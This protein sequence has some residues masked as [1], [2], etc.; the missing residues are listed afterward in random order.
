M[1][2]LC[3]GANIV[4]SIESCVGTRGEVDRRLL[5]I[6]RVPIALRRCGITGQ[7]GVVSIAAGLVSVGGVLV[8][9]L[10]VAPPCRPG[11]TGSSQL[12]QQLAELNIGCPETFADLKH[13][14]RKA[15]GQ[16]DSHRC[17]DPGA[18]QDYSLGTPLA[19]SAPG[20][21]EGLGGW[22]RKARTIRDGDRDDLSGRAAN[23]VTQPRVHGPSP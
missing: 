21:S 23:R 5:P 22:T 15:H 19:S 8:M 4:V 16:S 6:G 1:R 14:L 11:C 17:R 10:G 2:H 7:R 20:P 18:H 13:L 3:G 12:F 9:L